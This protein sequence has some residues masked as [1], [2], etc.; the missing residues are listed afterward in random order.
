MAG[1]KS[2]VNEGCVDMDKVHTLVI[3]QA[4]GLNIKYALTIFEL[5]PVTVDNAETAFAYLQKNTPDLLI[6][7]AHLEDMR[8]TILCD[9]V[10][11]VKRLK[12]T[13]VILFV[14]SQDR[15][16]VADAYMSQADEVLE[17]PFSARDLRVSVKTFLDKRL[18]KVSAHDGEQVTDVN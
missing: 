6:I 7:D 8:G 16:M 2:K 15:H 5:E 14:N 11:R 12:D 4:Q 9:R 18:P 13:H 3:S 1:V 10:K 17:L